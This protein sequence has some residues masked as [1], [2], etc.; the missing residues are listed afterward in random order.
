M[1]QLSRVN[2]HREENYSRTEYVKLQ[3][4]SIELRKVMKKR[5]E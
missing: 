5:E 3:Y 4:I 2:Q 1:V